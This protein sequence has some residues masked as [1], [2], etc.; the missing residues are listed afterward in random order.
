MTYVL[1]ARD[2]GFLALRALD[3]QCHIHVTALPGPSCMNLGHR[4]TSLLT[5]AL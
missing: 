4:G 3:W 2:T 5:P 1:Q